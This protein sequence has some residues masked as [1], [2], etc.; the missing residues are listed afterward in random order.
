MADAQLRLRPGKSKAGKS[1]RTES[2]V[3]DVLPKA[4]RVSVPLPL[5]ILALSC[6]LRFVGVASGDADVTVP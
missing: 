2:E 1:S 4:P 3:D 5:K 6:Q